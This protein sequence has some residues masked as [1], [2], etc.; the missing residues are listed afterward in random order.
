MY[1]MFDMFWWKMELCQPVE[2]T[3][4]FHCSIIPKASSIKRSI[5]LDRIS[6]CKWS[7]KHHQWYTESMF[8]ER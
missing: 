5:D 1:L 6:L 3:E 2:A 4:D 7:R 8:T